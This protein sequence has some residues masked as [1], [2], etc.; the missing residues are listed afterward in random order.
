MVAVI[1]EWGSIKEKTVATQTVLE[2]EI[3]V[4]KAADSGTPPV[5]QW[6]VV[7]V[8]LEKQAVSETAND[9]QSSAGV[10]SEKQPV[11][12]SGSTPEG[13]LP[14]YKRFWRWINEPFGPQIHV[15]S[16]DPTR[17]WRWYTV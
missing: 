15:I 11:T 12:A 17:V 8:D 7:P 5:L 2:E 6:E 4:E 3:R 1:L 13:R 14:Y 16:N 10:G 9:P